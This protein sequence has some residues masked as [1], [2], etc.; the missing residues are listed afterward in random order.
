MK[1]TRTFSVIN[2]FSENSFFQKFVA[3]FFFLTKPHIFNGSTFKL[4][5]FY[6]T[7]YSSM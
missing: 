3:F 6:C 2:I 4:L 7:G 1:E 5:V